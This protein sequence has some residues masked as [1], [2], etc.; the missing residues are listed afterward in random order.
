M[1]RWFSFDLVAHLPLTPYDCRVTN[2][3]AVH[4]QILGGVEMVLLFAGA[5][6]PRMIFHPFLTLAHASAKMPLITI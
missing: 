4:H 5:H 2:W 6:L 1:I 3:L